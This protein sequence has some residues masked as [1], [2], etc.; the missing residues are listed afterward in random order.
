MI[1]Y[2]YTI[3]FGSNWLTKYGFQYSPSYSQ[4]ILHIHKSEKNSLYIAQTW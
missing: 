4:C 3:T 1:S 2:G